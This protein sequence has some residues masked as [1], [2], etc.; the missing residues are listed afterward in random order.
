MDPLAVPP[1]PCF[2]DDHAALLA[3]TAEYLCDRYG[4]IKPDWV[5]DPIYILAE[6]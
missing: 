3:G 2:E 4:L 1:P 6:E 5:D